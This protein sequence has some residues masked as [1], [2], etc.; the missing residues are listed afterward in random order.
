V[1]LIAHVSAEFWP[2]HQ[3]TGIL[4]GSSTHLMRAL[5]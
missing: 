3:K 4:R 1:Q 2:N 5:K